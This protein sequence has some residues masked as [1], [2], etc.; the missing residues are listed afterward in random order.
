VAELRARGGSD[1]DVAERCCKSLFEL[2]L[3]AGADAVAAV[4]SVMVAHRRGC[5]R[6]QQAGCMALTKLADASAD[7]RAA[8]GRCGGL[9]AVVAAMQS[10]RAD[11]AVLLFCCLALDAF[12]NREAGPAHMAGAAGA[13]E[14]L[15]AAMAAH[16]NDPVVQ[17]RAGGMLNVL[18]CFDATSH[19]ARRAGAAGAV[20]V[21]LSA[22]RA[23]AADVRMQASVCAGLGNIAAD[24]QSRVQ[25]INAGA[26]EAILAALNSSLTRAIA[27]DTFLLQ[28]GCTAIGNLCEAVV[29][30]VDAR[31]AALV[32]DATRTILAALDAHP[33]HFNLQRGGCLALG[34]FADEVQHKAAVAR[35]GAIPAIVRALRLHPAAGDLQR[36]CCKTLSA[37]CGKNSHNADAACAAGAIALVVAAMRT[38]A[39][40]NADGQADACLALRDMVSSRAHQAA[41]GSAGAVEAIVLALRAHP[42]HQLVQF[43]G[44]TSLVGLLF[45][46]VLNIRAAVAAG[47]IGSVTAAIGVL[48]SASA[49]MQPHV[50]EACCIALDVLIHDSGNDDAHALIAMSAGAL[51]AVLEH[52]QPRVVGS[53]W[54]DVCYQRL[55]EQLRAAAARHDADGACAADG[56]KRCAGMRAR[57]ELCGAPGCSARMRADDNA[58]K[59]LR[60]GRCRVAAYCCVAHQQE[61]WAH[62]KPECR[63]GTQQG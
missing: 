40:D 43:A 48:A 18:L 34:V 62:H 28:H 41:A 20:A 58:K 13:V 19:N 7:N 24:A 36:R 32:G 11:A 14:A 47:A 29:A 39:G 26:I 16:V 6:V 56:C 17:S 25:A 37:L 33:A 60:C 57:G 54:G 23:H 63:R 44:C 15:V 22:M 55:P 52:E 59:L 4:A 10:C 9:E 30:A 2:T 3:P 27:D 5:A 8:V 21:L 42:T 1:A 35:A 53:V 49:E 31:S 51:E 12:V 38:F 46:N 45:R 50:Y 61:D